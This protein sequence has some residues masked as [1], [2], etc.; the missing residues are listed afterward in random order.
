MGT[1]LGT[2][3]RII[4]S[5]ALMVCAIYGL[6]STFV[7]ADLHTFLFPWIEHIRTAGPVNAFREPF[8]NYTPPY[9]YLLAIGTL[10]TDNSLVIVK[11]LGVTSCGFAA[12]AVWRLVHT[13]RSSILAAVTSLSLP[14]MIIDG[15]MLGQCDSIWV[16]LCLLSVAAAIEGQMLA[17]VICCGIAFAFKAQATFIAPFVLT[18]LLQRRANIVLWI[19][20]PAIYCVAMLPAW[21]AGWPAVDLATI[22]LR[23]A[24]YFNTIGSSP[25]LWAIGVVILPRKPTDLFL[26]GYA[27]GIIFS[28]AY[29]IVLCR[30]KLL[31]E[32]MI[33]AALVSALAL[34]FLLPKMHERFTLLADLLALSLAFVS[35]KRAN[36]LVATAVV[37]ASSTGYLSY[38]LAIDWLP[39]IGCVVNAWVLFELSKRLFS[40]HGEPGLKARNS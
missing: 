6:S 40:T 3:G 7:G 8:G 11:V 38:M 28:V 27:A 17:M 23:Q 22:Y 20:P 2:N 13:E 4:A 14:T 34:P 26:I 25:G 1:G 16:A 29:V 39:I 36:G 10:L 33:E 12:I 24:E 15:P 35:P 18:V 21:S 37:G 5:I 31:R 19:V 30:R 9:L 32:Q